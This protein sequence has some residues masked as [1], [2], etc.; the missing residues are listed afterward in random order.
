MDKREFY[1][2]K[3]KRAEYLAVVFE[4]PAFEEPLRL[5]ANQFAELTLGGFVHIPCPMQVKEPEQ[6]S[7]AQ[8]KLTVSF[9]RQVV[10]REFKR[11]LRLVTDSGSR[12]PITVTYSVYMGDTDVPER[13]WRLFVSDSGGITFGNETVQVTASDDN[14]MRRTAGPIY[15]PGVFTGLILI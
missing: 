6:A 11:Q 8:P 13:L 9:P 14:P 10:G 2:T 3:S 5:V 15:D 1:S 7:G 4:H 12:D